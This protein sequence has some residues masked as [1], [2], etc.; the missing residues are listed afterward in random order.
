MKTTLIEIYLDNSIEKSDLE[1]RQF[2][3]DTI[4]SKGL[5]EVVEETSSQYMMEIVVETEGNKEIKPDVKSLLL[6][7]GCANFNIKDIFIEE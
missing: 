5:G 2:I 6:S 4:E 1:F 3:V 7:L